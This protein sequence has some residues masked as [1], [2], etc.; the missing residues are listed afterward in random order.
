VPWPTSQDYNEAVQNPAVCFADPELRRGRA[1]ANSL[2]LPM[3]CSGNFADVYHVT[4]P[5]GAWAVKC[6]TR[7]VAGLR[8]RY[9]AV[10]TFLERARLRFMVDCRYLTE[11]VRVRGQWYP[12]VK[13]RWVDGHLLNEFVRDSLDRP[14]LLD[15]LLHL[16][17]RMARR[18]RVA[19]MAH[20]DLQH[21]NVILTP[22]EGRVSHTV[23]LVDY[24]GVWV[25]ALAGRR[26][27][28][29]GHANYQH[30]QRLREG[31][32]SPEVDR[33]P[34]LVVATALCCLRVAGRGL[35]DRW[36][37]GDNLLFKQADFAH[38]HQSKLFAELLRL[39]DAEARSVAAQLM[40]ACQKPLE[41]T[42][43]LEEVF[44]RRPAA[45]AAPTAGPSYLAP[46][47]VR[48]APQ[49]QV[50]PIVAPPAAVPPV[51]E[52]Q[53]GPGTSVQPEPEVP[54]YAPVWIPQ[55]RKQAAIVL[56]L[57]VVFLLAILIGAV[58]VSAL[59]PG[60]ETGS[61][62]VPK[63]EPGPLAG[64]NLAPAEN[65]IAAPGPDQPP[66]MGPPIVPPGPPPGPAPPPA[67][68]PK[69][70]Q[71]AEP[72]PPAN[73]GKPPAPPVANPPIE[74]RNPADRGPPEKFSD[75]IARGVQALKAMQTADG[76]W[77]AES[78]DA[79]TKVG[80]TAL[81]G[82]T[83]LEC[84]IPGED[85]SVARAAEAVRAAA[86]DLRHTYSL[87]LNILFLDRLGDPKDIPLIEL[88]GLRLVAGQGEVGGWSYRCPEVIPRNDCELQVKR[89]GELM[90]GG[91]M[92]RVGEGG[93]TA[94]D[95]PAYIQEGLKKILTTPN[96][97]M[98]QGGDNSNTQFAALGLWTARR[99]GI[100]VEIAMSRLERRFREGQNPDGGWSYQSAHVGAASTP[101]MTC[102]GILALAISYGLVGEGR[103]ARDPAKDQQMTLALSALGS[104]IGQR[105]AK[106]EHKDYYF[107]WALERVCVIL[108]RQ[109]VGNT[110]WYEWGSAI[111]V[112]SQDADGL[113][114]GDFARCGAD[115][116]FALLF[117]KRAN[118]ARDLAP[119]LPQNEP[120][121][122]PNPKAPPPRGGVGAPPRAPAGG[123][124]LR[125]GAGPGGF[126]PGFT[127]RQ[128]FRGGKSGP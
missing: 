34:L 42:P 99:Y 124:G 33:F 27:G 115:T 14:T 11:G 114:R 9:A 113:W 54:V 5:G 97:D 55:P 122:E 10:S 126:P 47:P 48:V 102:A 89:R 26:S 80:A 95:L 117:L 64:A 28:E 20:G 84:N 43:L 96:R 128:G 119:R 125:P 23:K 109:K 40:A 50:P 98:P 31:T 57:L 7:Q 110:D 91:K 107:L 58:L 24:D 3:P 21:G 29:V 25:P 30:P 86:L 15:R 108:N 118:L 104:C 65:P 60:P 49:G 8:E 59:K 1:A 41:Q 105:I 37:N 67:I 72:N 32:D 112:K 93:R 61:G 83:L 44:A 18:L 17:V 120:K 111:L 101:T 121:P 100:P 77:P 79:T 75:N 68:N 45:V 74:K 6:F 12:V 123:P 127:P 63:Q 87:A 92:P 62:A 78:V 53:P 69:P 46:P 52:E 39:P 94:N 70:P 106:A 90:A 85:P 19:K 66:E 13:M 81:A 76:C 71:P 116:C 16:W 88:M 73:P 103:K 82:L 36:D 35:W 2:G 38:P 22:E 56:V 4:G 51:Q